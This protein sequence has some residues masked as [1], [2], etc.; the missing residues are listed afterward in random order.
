M[1][2]IFQNSQFSRP[3]YS[4]FDLSHEKKFSLKMGKLVPI[5]VSD[6]MPGDKFR[7]KTE[8]FARMAPML[9]PIMHRVNVYT[10]HFFVPNRLLWTEWEDFITGG[11][12]GQSVPVAPYIMVNDTTAP[13]FQKGSLADFLGVPPPPLTGITQPLKVSALPFRAY[14]QIYNDY[15]RDQNIQPEVTAGTGGGDI[16]TGGDFQNAVVL[17]SRA[18]EKDYFT[19]ALPWSQRGGQVT[20]P[21]SAEVNYKNTSAL[22]DTTTGLPYPNAVLTS[23]SAGNLE[24]SPGFNARIE[25]IEDISNGISTIND[26]RKAVRL[27]EWLEKSARGG[28][29]YI[30]QIMSHFGVKS[31]DARLQRA[32][33]LGGGKS[34]MT[35]SEVLSTYQSAASGEPDVNPQ[36]NMSGHGYSVGSNHGFTKTFEE[37]GY[38]IS[39]MSILPK[40]A[41]S[42]GLPR[43]LSRFDKLDYPW[44]TFGQLGEQEVRNKELYADYTAVTPNAELEFGYQSRYAECKFMPSTIHGDF[45][46]TLE[47]WHMGRKFAAQPLLN[48]SFI[49]ADPTKRIFAVEDDTVDEIYCQ[50][51]HDVSAIRALPYFNNPTL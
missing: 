4:K 37:H 10:H 29:R 6:V 31:S 38:V 3:K 47:Y 5:M 43:H 44:P 40:T 24:A 2:N 13:G 35:I 18:W 26:L 51:Y 32:E 36:G 14:L 7:V 33:Y 17:R 23:D 28:A 11:P 42:Q 15:Y 1:A 25:N 27:Q 16:G 21:F 34:P 39:I 12:T 49:Q 45:R 48:E 46:D 50:V 9:A 30:E 19:S 20:M 8:I 41:Y 22:V